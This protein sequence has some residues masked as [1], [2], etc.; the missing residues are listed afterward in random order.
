MI[1]Q[2]CNTKF[3]PDEDPI[4]PGCGWK[5]K[6]D[7]GEWIPDR[8]IEKESLKTQGKPGEERKESKKEPEYGEGYARGFKEGYEKGSE[9]EESKSKEE[10][11][12]EEFGVF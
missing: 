10:P 6:L 9:K 3:Y 4:C 8:K 5:Y 2:Y 7:K 1:C 12:E 11:E